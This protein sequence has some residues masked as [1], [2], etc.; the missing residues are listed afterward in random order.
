MD[1]MTMAEERKSRVYLL[2]DGREH[3]QLFEELRF[4]GDS[5]DCTCCDA[6]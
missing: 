4:T 6:F 5:A 2:D 1:S 3:T